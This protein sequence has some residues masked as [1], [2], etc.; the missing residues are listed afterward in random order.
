MQHN[1]LSSLGR[2]KRL[3]LFNVPSTL[4]SRERRFSLA[5]SNDRNLIYGR[6]TIA[7]AGISQRF[8]LVPTF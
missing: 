8:Q 4:G 7:G 5:A 3:T 2:R 6:H 1:M